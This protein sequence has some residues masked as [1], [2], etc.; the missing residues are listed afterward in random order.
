MESFDAIYR[1]E[2]AIQAYLKTQRSFLK[3]SQPAAGPHQPFFGQ[4]CAGAAKKLLFSA[5]K[6][7]GADPHQLCAAKNALVRQRNCSSLQKNALVRIHTSS[8]LQKMPWCGSTPALRYRSKG[9]G[10]KEG[11]GG[12]RSYGEGGINPSIHIQYYHKFDS[13]IYSSTSDQ[14]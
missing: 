6:C 8:A 10:G 13:L 9:I 4:K 3:R 7:A 2:T 5:K 1:I 11:L 14:N 12:G